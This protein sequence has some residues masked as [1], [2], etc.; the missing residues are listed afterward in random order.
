MTRKPLFL[1]TPLV[2]MAC[3]LPPEAD[4]LQ[5]AW[6]SDG[7][8]IAAMIDGR[9]VETFMISDRTCISEGR[10]PLWGL[11]QVF[12]IEISPDNRAFLLRQQNTI[13]AI[14][15][16]RV[17]ALP[18][19]CTHPPANTPTANL[20]A[21]LDIYASH[22]AFFDLY[23]V[24]WDEQSA[25]ARAQVSDATTDADLFAVMVNAIAP[26]P[27]GHIGLKANIN[28]TRQ[29]FE[30]NPGALFARIQAQARTAGQN[31]QTAELDFRN[32]YRHVH[33][34]QT[35]LN[36]RGTTAGNGFVQYGFVSPKV[37]YINFLTMAAFATGDIGDLAGDIDAVNDIL[38]DAIE[39]FEQAGVTNVILDL[40]LNFGGYDDVALT[41]A[42]R[43]AA[44]PVF[45]YSE[46]PADADDPITLR[47]IVVPSARQTYTGPLTL[48]TSDMTV[49]AG[50]IL[51]LALRP[52]P[53]VTHVG[54]ATR[55][56][57]SDVLEMTLPN[58][59][60]VELSNE[61]YT[62]H[63]GI[64][65]EG[66]GITPDHSVAVFDGSDPLATH[67]GA[68]GYAANLVR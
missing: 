64:I 18:D 53:Q 42:N 45:A 12:D 21:F 14:Q 17:A 59:W 65:W 55:G 39:G 20:E 61:I 67:L 46:Y 25:A 13:Q 29:L 7:Y 54:E 52:L 30:P 62:D 57:F 23:D 50:E 5:G 31:P 24:D 15:F 6:V 58:G 2:C 43:F 40:S 34:P 8:G 9:S 22:Y 56:A 10:D 60:I 41:I 16:N 27:D 63:Q 38:D 1:L 47:R 28:G 44:E 3:A 51:T 36:G 66:R 11:F 32:H 33:I 49:S 48:L 68:I 35:I 4:Q 26:L 37:G 19:H